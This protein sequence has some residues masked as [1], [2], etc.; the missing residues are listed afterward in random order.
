MTVARRLALAAL[1]VGALLLPAGAGAATIVVPRTTDAP[2]GGFD[3]EGCTL[4]DA[5]MAANTNSSHPL[6]C[7]GDNAGADTIVLQS[8]QT[9]TLSFHGVDDT[10]AAGDLDITGPV[11]I[12]SSGP[13]LARINAASN[14]LPG[15]P[16]GADRALHVLASAGDVTLEGIRVEGGFVNHSAAAFGGGGGIRAESLLTLRRSEV[17]DNRVEGG[18][19]ILGGGIWAHGPTARLRVFESTIAGNSLLKLGSNALGGGI[20]AYPDATE[21]TIEN[22]T[23]SGNKAEGQFAEAG[24]IF[25][26]DYLNS[27]L[28]TLTNVTVAGNSADEIGGIWL[29]GSLTGSLVAGNT[30]ANPD[31]NF[32]DCVGSTSLTSGGGNLIGEAHESGWCMFKETGDAFGTE[33][34]P[35][36]PNLGTLVNNGGPTRTRAPNTGSPAINRGGPCPATDQRGLFRFAAAPCDA[37]A[38]EVG[39]SAT[40]PPQP[41]PPPATPPPPPPATLAMPPPPAANGATGQRAAALARCGKLKKATGKQTRKARGKCRVK[42]QKLPL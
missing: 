21:L 35:I 3:D 18:T 29:R 40:P 20:T 36:N 15:P 28:S 33:A 23:I 34:A 26:G 42:A 9:Y 39:A 5:V 4:R 1:A 13:G 2:N 31:A 11:T 7:V 17:V 14:T 19:Y 27:A 30:A 8:G 16:T 10:N 12:R 24:G 25:G 37:G 6:G 41:S 22:S 38:V 32:P